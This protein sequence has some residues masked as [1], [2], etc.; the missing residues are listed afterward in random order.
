MVSPTFL[1][2]P[3]PECAGRNPF[4]PEFIASGNPPRR[5]D[6]AM[7]NRIAQSIVFIFLLFLPLNAL[8]KASLSPSLE[9]ISIQTDTM[10]TDSL[11]PVILFLDNVSI[12]N[13]I[14]KISTT[15]SLNPQQR[16]KQVIGTLMANGDAI[17]GEMKERIQKIYHISDFTEFWITPALAFR[18]PFSKLKALA[19]LPGVASIVE[20]APV[21]LISPVET[22]PVSV[23]KPAVLNH[24]ETL[25]IPAIWKRGLKGKGRL[26]CSF[27]T[28]VEWTHPALQEKWRG[29]HSAP[30]AAWFAPSVSDTLPTDKSGHGTHTMGLMVGNEADSFG[31]APEAEWI[32]AGVID[33]GQ[34]LSR[35]IS[36]ILAAFQWAVDPDGNPNTTDDVPDVILNSWG[37][38]L[39]VLP[40]GDETFYGAIDNVEAFGIVTIFAAGNEGPN[41][42]TI[43]LPADRA[44]TPLNAFAVGAI[45]DA[46]NTIAG[47]SSRGPSHGD[48][49]QIKPEVVAPGVFIYSSWENGTYC[50]MSG[51]SMA[52]PYIAGLVALLRQY[53]PVATVDEIKN[54]I[55]GS[56]RDLGPLGE[57]NS[58]GWGLPDAE[59]AVELLPHPPYPKVQLVSKFIGVD[60]I[61]DPGE[62]FDLFLQLDVPP[63]SLDSIVGVLSVDDP[64]VIIHSNRGF[65][66]LGKE[67]SRPINHPSYAISFDRSL[68]NGQMVPFTLRLYSPFDDSVDILDFNIT[69]GR[70]PNGKMITHITPKIKFTVSDFGQLG[71]GINSIFP[72]GGAGFQFEQSE[73]ILYEAGI[74]VGR[75]ALQISSCVRDSLGR[76][77]QS[78]FNPI[79]DLTA[80]YSDPDGGFGSHSRFVDAQSIIPIPITISQ[81]VWSYSQTGEDD[82]III[83]YFLINNSLENLTDLYFGFLSDFDLSSTGDRVG[84][85][86]DNLLYQTGDSKWIGILPLTETN[87]II[88]LKN[89]SMKTALNNQQKI[90]Y[91]NQMGNRVDDSSKADL[92]TLHSFG[93]FNLESY[94]SAAVALA[95]VAASDSVS[96][97]MAAT[98]S[99]A[100]YWGLTHVTTDSALMPIGYK[101]FQNYPN[102][103]NPSTQITF[104][105][106]RITTA[107]LAIYDILG[108]KVATLFEGQIQ[109]GRHTVIWHGENNY[110]QPVP[111]GVYFYR[112][113]TDTAVFSKKM[114]L[115]K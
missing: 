78:D 82:Y 9:R 84:L 71:M 28:G 58:Y 45:N 114:L 8:S 10:K 99:A 39:S 57:D 6:A 72:A 59:R 54:A 70:A 44:T 113:K 41:P 36:D 11:V 83:K 3:E 67:G 4:L 64:K 56:A 48:T 22:I 47:F 31:V 30:A 32:T 7:G 81:S 108:R 33:Q 63:T 43:R 98:R 38:P 13:K 94:D 18:I 51:T 93:P 25:N 89:D 110:T 77:D 74:I 111:S 106:P 69:V 53:N 91:I 88:T 21:D 96:L 29:N 85:L 23:A 1:Y 50:L 90:D 19:Q 92:M 5:T 100:R 97:E 16:H 52:A 17:W 15:P 105:I 104:E 35:T 61:A 42:K 20:D 24:L 102:P 87:G 112:L 37:I 68:I 12:K 80:D 14:Y 46:S 40:P 95:L 103:F 79:L 76:A 109:P 49:T 73:N 62:T 86:P 26:I 2:S 55:I 66:V 107:T 65:F 60:G 27:D 115:L 75:N 34:T 101:L